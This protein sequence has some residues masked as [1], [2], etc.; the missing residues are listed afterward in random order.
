MAPYLFQSNT[1]NTIVLRTRDNL[2][3]DKR[4]LLVDIGQRGLERNITANREQK[5]RTLSHPQ[6]SLRRPSRNLCIDWF[7]MPNWGG[8]GSTWL[9]YNSLYC[10]V[11]AMHGGVYERPKKINIACLQAEIWTRL[12]LTKFHQPRP[13]K[14]RRE[15]RTTRPGNI[16]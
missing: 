1:V 12:C 2:A 16:S 10:T 8:W 7:L 11:P 14:P 3:S 5:S 4:F 9:W 13:H 6:S 15:T